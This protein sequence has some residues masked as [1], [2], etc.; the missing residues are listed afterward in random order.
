VVAAGL[1]RELFGAVVP[2]PDGEIAY[3]LEAS[4]KSVYRLDCRTDELD[5]LATCC[6][7][8]WW[9]L[10]NLSLGPRGE[11]LF[12][13]SN[14]NA[15]SSVRAI[16]VESGGCREVLDVDVLLGTRDLC[17]GGQNVWDRNGNLYAPV[18]TFGAAQPDLALLRVSL[19]E[20]PRIG[21]PSESPP[22]SR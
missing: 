7:S 18:W 8:N 4:T 17:F 14:N 2:A 11:E 12:Y 3:F 15:K 1:P 19:S 21:R 20:R 16:D 5:F 9:K 6:G 13:V 22:R 10:F